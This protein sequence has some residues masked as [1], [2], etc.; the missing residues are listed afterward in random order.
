[1]QEAVTARYKV[2]ASLQSQQGVNVDV[3]TKTQMVIAGMKVTN[4]RLG[5]RNGNTE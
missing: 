1:M 2:N 3:R 5:G 4:T